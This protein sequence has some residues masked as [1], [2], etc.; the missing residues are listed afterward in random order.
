MRGKMV[1]IILPCRNERETVGMCVREAWAAARAAGFPAE[2]IVSDSSTDGSDIIA[3][4][5]GAVVVKHN[6]EGYG[7]AVREGVKHATGDTL[8]YADADGTYALK[9]I[10]EL[11]KDLG[12]ADIVIGSRLRGRMAPGA[13]PIAHRLFG[14][15]V[16]NLLLFAIF[17]LKVSDSQSGFRAIRREAFD[18]L[19]LKT[20]GMEFATEML[21]KAKQL[22]LRVVETPITYS[23]RRGVSKLRRYRDGL[24]H[25]RYLL[26]Q[27][28]ISWYIVP[29]ALTFALGIVALAFSFVW[30]GLPFFSSATARLFFPILGFEMIFLGAFAKT[31]L[32][33]RF[34]EP[35]RF[36]AR[37]N[38]VL[39]SKTALAIGIVLICL[40]A[41]LRLIGVGAELFDPLFVSVLLGFMLIAD[42]FILS[43][44]N[45]GRPSQ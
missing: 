30:P 13:M 25:I 31:F 17:G 18:Q 29:G 6:R 23:V 14:T 5:A 37:F 43:V 24:A 40:P 22:G 42:L 35:N 41:A 2:V 9:E 15:P 39:R 4:A 19:A 11:L 20:D 44:V 16:L 1:S 36:A 8:V 26:L 38:A 28:P 27:T 21:V 10:P 34:R 3:R 45:T 7:L 33:T 12:A 32:W